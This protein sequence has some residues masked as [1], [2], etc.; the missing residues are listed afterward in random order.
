MNKFSEIET[1]MLAMFGAGAALSVSSS[2][3]GQKGVWRTG[4]RYGRT[5]ADC[6]RGAEIGH[7]VFIVERG[8]YED[9][10]EV[11]WEE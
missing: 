11:F 9:W 10:P 6:A 8:V 5:G 7:F 3:S 2:L 4:R 1:G